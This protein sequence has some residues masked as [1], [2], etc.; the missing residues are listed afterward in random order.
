MKTTGKGLVGNFSQQRRSGPGNVTA[1]STEA[2]LGPLICQNRLI[3]RAGLPPGYTPVLEKPA[4][5]PSPSLASPLPQVTAV[6]QGSNLPCPACSE[7]HSARGMP[8]LP[9]AWQQLCGALQ[10]A[11][12]KVG[13]QGPF[14][15]P[16]TTPC[17]QSPG[18]NYRPSSPPREMG[19]KELCIL[20]RVI[21]KHTRR[22]DRQNRRKPKAILL[23]FHERRS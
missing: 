9:S 17:S 12:A 19:Q 14:S 5:E 20:L 22:R 18:E 16:A 11:W 2:S 15:G 4:W 10:G 13:L 21:V 6:S 8:A 7:S 23:S 3:P 1:R